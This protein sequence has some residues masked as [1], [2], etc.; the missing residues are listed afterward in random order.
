MRY[1]HGHGP[2]VLSNHLTR[3]AQDSLAFVLPHL[4]RD[5]R[6]LDVGCGRGSRFR[7]AARGVVDPGVT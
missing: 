1:T 3:T 6:V 5:S 4:H 7:D 2:A